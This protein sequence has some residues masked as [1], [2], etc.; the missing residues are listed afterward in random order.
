MCSWRKKKS[1]EALLS[2]RSLNS[3]F[4]QRWRYTSLSDTAWETDFLKINLYSRQEWTYWW[5]G[6]NRAGHWLQGLGKLGRQTQCW[7]LTVNSGLSSGEGKGKRPVWGG[8]TGPW[9]LRA[10]LPLLLCRLI[11]KGIKSNHSTVYKQNLREAKL[12][13]KLDTI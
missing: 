7:G 3:D 10:P 1:K 9:A 12:I 8:K 4:L 11:S 2:L 6:G 13:L 5:V